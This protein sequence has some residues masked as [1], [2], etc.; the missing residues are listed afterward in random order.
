MV[1]KAYAGI[2]SRSTPTHIQQLM[3]RIAVALGHDGYTLRSGAAQG[4]D[5]AFAAGAIDADIFLPWP[6]FGPLERY[7]GHRYMLRP[8]KAA[9]DLAREFHPR[10]SSLGQGAQK[11]QAR[12]SHQVLGGNLDDPVRFVICWTDQAKAQGGTGQAIRLA[13]ARN[14]PVF[15]LA[16]EATYTRLLAYVTKSERERDDNG[17]RMLPTD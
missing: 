10:W 8:T 6:T 11:L 13:K 4:A 9:A 3:T 7:A 15:D 14:I 16:D 2:G 17:P 12:N 1:T 5:T